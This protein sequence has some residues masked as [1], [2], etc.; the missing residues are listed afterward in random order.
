MYL[1]WEK[2]LTQPSV[3]FSNTEKK[4]HTSHWLT[5][6]D[7]RKAELKP[8]DWEN[9]QVL[10]A[11]GAQPEDTRSGWAGRPLPVILYVGAPKKSFFVG[12]G[13]LPSYIHV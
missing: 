7:V 5:P 2:T 6:S 4:T 11:L 1:N 8:I 3:N 13:S 12:K 9:S 10:E